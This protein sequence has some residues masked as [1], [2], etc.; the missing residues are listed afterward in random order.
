MVT[1]L[2]EFPGRR[3]TCS[4]HI[5]DHIYIGYNDGSLIQ[6]DLNKNV[7]YSGQTHIGPIYTIFH[8]TNKLII[9]GTHMILFCEISYPLVIKIACIEGQKP[10]CS[11]TFGDISVYSD[12]D[13]IILVK[14]VNMIL[15]RLEYDKYIHAKYTPLRLCINEDTIGFVYNCVGI[16]KIDHEFEKTV[17]INDENNGEITLR[18]GEDEVHVKIRL[19]VSICIWRGVIVSSSSSSSPHPDFPHPSSTCNEA[20]IRWRLGANGIYEPELFLKR[21]PLSIQIMDDQLFEFDDCVV[22][23][24]NWNKVHLR[25]FDFSSDF[26]GKRTRHSLLLKGNIFMF[27]GNGTV[28]NRTGNII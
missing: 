15:G 18:D 22:N 27:N 25:T 24:W 8:H 20:I 5:N 14:S 17:C 21:C 2:I 3:V 16:Y 26:D 7:F 13:G 6:M 11:A 4:H 12:S 23:C 10:R 9:C 19:V 1:D 28:C